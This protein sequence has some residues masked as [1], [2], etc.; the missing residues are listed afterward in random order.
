M[1][2]RGDV[3]HQRHVPLPIRKSSSD[4]DVG[5]FER[6]LDHRMAGVIRDR[7]CML[8]DDD[9]DGVCDKRMLYRLRPSHMPRATSTH[10]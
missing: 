4:S 5:Q 1:Q 10:R 9:E 8:T 2:I 7:K 3:F 6:D